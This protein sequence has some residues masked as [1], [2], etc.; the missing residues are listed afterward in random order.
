MGLDMH[1]EKV[2]KNLVVQQVMDQI[3]NLIATDQFKPHE[4]IPTE[5]ELAEMFGTGRTTIREAIKVFQ[6][7]GILEPHPRKGTFV[8][9]YSNVSTEALTWSILLGRHEIYDLVDLRK[10]IEQRAL[11]IILENGKKD[12]PAIEATIK[13]LRDDI[14]NMKKAQFDTSLEDLIEEDY[15]FHGTIIKACENEVYINIYQTLR[16]FM[17]EEIKKTSLDNEANSIAIEEHKAIVDAIESMDKEATITAHKNHI[18]SIIEQLKGS[19]QK[20]KG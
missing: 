19:L 3:K 11:E 12:S 17:H 5:T 18:T 6:H 16:S 1:I 20:D 8:C 14:E 2:K 10:I 7:L 4:K 13:I 9:D 15:H